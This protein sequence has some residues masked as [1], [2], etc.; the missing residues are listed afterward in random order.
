[1]ALEVAVGKRHYQLSLPKLVAFSQTYAALA[2]LAVAHLLEKDLD[3]A[4][5]ALSELHPPAGKLSLVPTPSGALILDSSREATPESMLAALHTLR[6]WSALPAE[7]SAKAGRRIAVL[8]DLTDQAGE[9]IG[10]H[11]K[12]G[13]AAAESTHI[14]VAVGQHMRYAGGEALLR[15][16]GPDVHHFLTPSEVGE[17]IKPYLAANDVILIMGSPDMH[18]EKIVA[19]LS[20]TT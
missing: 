6:T 15:R 16:P 19:D 5:A 1:F 8:G 20:N 7:A 13:R 3:R 11:K 2:A 17:W 14:F 18:M 12:I 10:A 4:A 9:T